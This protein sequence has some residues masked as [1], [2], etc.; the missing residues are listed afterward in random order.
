M[1][2]DLSPYE[3]AAT[4]H[5]IYLQITKNITINSKLNQSLIDSSQFSETFF[6][7]SLVQ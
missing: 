5:F 4:N 1:G 2:I 6:H 7:K 3:D